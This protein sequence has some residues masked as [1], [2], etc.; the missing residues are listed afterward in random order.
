MLD[1]ADIPDHSHSETASEEKKHHE[2]VA[3]NDENYHL[4]KERNFVGRLRHK[5][6]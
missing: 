4:P 1:P 2:S 5:V 6:I 3:I